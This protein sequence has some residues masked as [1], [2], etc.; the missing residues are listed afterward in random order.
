MSCVFLEL[1]SSLSY[2]FIFSLYLFFSLRKSFRT[3]QGGTPGGLLQGGAPSKV[4]F[5]RGLRRRGVGVKE[6]GDGVVPLLDG[7]GVL[8]FAKLQGTRRSNNIT[9]ERWRCK[10]GAA[11]SGKRE[12]ENEGI[13]RINACRVLLKV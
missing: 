11:H 12:K 2:D 13:N 9:H 4:V 8:G 7:E 10:Q 1:P 5:R 6:G 3:L